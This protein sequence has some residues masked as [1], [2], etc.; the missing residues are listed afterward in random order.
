MFS[1]V[2]HLFVYNG[3]MRLNQ[4]R[5]L[6]CTRTNTDINVLFPFPMPECCAS[7][8]WNLRCPTVSPAQ[9]T[10]VVQAERR[11]AWRQRRKHFS[12]YSKWH[13]L[14]QEVKKTTKKNKLDKIHH[15]CHF[16]ADLGS[17]ATRS[18]GVWIGRGKHIYGK[19][20]SMK[21][22]KGKRHIGSCPVPRCVLGSLS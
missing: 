18:L 9:L 12:R 13:R 19:P 11:S 7:P 1:L 17:A 22:W 6:I 10:I 8:G 16:E 2:Q 15:L 5:V 21:L 14:N 20:K 4:R 3:V